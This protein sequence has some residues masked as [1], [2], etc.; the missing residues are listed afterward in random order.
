M[1][2][3]EHLGKFTWHKT[4]CHVCG[5]E[6]ETIFPNAPGLCEAC[7]DRMNAEHRKPLSGDL[8][9]K[10]RE[11]QWITRCPTDFQKFDVN[12]L[13]AN[14][15][16]IRREDVAEILRWQYSSKGI[17]LYGHSGYGKS[18]IMWAL[19]RRLYVEDGMA[20]EHVDAQFANRVGALFQDSVALGASFVEKLSRAQILFMDEITQKH[21]TQRAEDEIYNILNFRYA[22]G[23]PVFG[24]DNRDKS[25][26]LSSSTDAT[27]HGMPIWNRLNVVADVKL[28]GPK[29]IDGAK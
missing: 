6:C 17:V 23:L 19:M 26:Y 7:L 11:K 5:V 9:K 20:V 22:N 27:T 13:C 29:K 16:E 10:L 24:T 21:I 3:S 25:L 15:P 14:K 12:I 8:L 28:W 2:L 1:N 4:T 18:R